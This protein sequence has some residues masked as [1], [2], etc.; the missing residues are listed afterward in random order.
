MATE[1]QIK[2][3]ENRKIVDLG[4]EVEVDGKKHRLMKFDK[5]MSCNDCSLLTHCQPK[6]DLCYNCGE[7][8]ATKIFIPKEDMNDNINLINYLKKL[9][10]WKLFQK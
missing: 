2:I 10:S 3:I 5:F 7:I 6:G 9:K 8:G 1:K 4:I